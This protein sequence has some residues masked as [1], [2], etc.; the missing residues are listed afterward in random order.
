MVEAALRNVEVRPLPPERLHPLIG[1]ERAAR[2]EAAAEAARALLAGRTVWN[3]NS[4]ATGGGVAELLQTLL[5]YARGVGVDAQWRVIEGNAAF[6]DVTKRV[7]NH[8]YGMPGDGGPLGSAEREVY[9]RTLAPN[10]DAL[11]ALSRPQDIV[12]LHDPQAAGL[13]AAAKSTGARV[14]WRCHVGVDEQNEHSEEAWEF[15]RRHLD[16][17]DAFVFSCEQ[18]APAWVDRDRLV[19][20]APSIDPFAAKNEPMPAENVVPLLRWV[21]LL[22]GA[23][24]APD[25]RFTRRDGSPGHVTCQVDM[26]GTGRPP[27]EVPL[28]MQAS[29]WDALKD[30]GGVMRAFA[31]RA[32]DLDEAHLLL[33]GPAPSGVMDDPESGGVLADCLALWRSFSP[34]LRA[35]LHLVSVPMRD[36]DEA[37]TIVNALQRHA[38]VV[39]QKSIAEGFGLTVAEA[40]WKARPVVGTRVGGIA[41]QIVPGE[42]GWLVDD[43]HDL[44]AFAKSVRALLAD[45]ADAERMG[46]NGQVRA[47]ERYLGD[48]HLQQWAALFHALG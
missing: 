37:A 42:T 30:M 7:H 3:V 6:F 12:L 18:F 20:I 24:E 21:G 34:R 17:V 36:P 22:D 32:A 23:T 1:P 33:A 25:V 31:E 11:R 26:L 39:T 13:A 9:E 45:P 28:V 19:V 4:T 2:F 5:A 29:R 41:E 38:S 40:M 43:P 14:V 16:A 46:T 8:L 15:L 27:A 10:A 48:R 47:C 35:R 44:D